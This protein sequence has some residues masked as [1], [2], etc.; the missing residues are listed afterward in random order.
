ME[1][2]KYPKCPICRKSDNV[3]PTITN[4]LG[5]YVCIKC[6]YIFDDK[7]QKQLVK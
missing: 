5:N 7:K 3:F 4:P 2:V 1:E 6:I